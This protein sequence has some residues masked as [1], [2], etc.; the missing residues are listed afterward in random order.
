MTSCNQFFSLLPTLFWPVSWLFS[1]PKWLPSKDSCGQ[2]HRKLE[3]RTV[4]F[5]DVI[6]T[7]CLLLWSFTNC[8]TLMMA[9]LLLYSLTCTPYPCYDVIQLLVLLSLSFVSYTIFFQSI[10]FEWLAGLTL[11]LWTP[12]VDSACIYQLILKHR[13]RGSHLHITRWSVCNRD[14]ESWS[15][16]LVLDCL[17]LHFRSPWLV[18]CPCYES[19][20]NK[21]EWA[22]LNHVHV[23]AP[24]YLW[25][26]DVDW[27]LHTINLGHAI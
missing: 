20:M 5:A 13:S 16:K 7:L 11:T 12:L 18:D 8:A 21:R 6:R 9:F 10:L 19:S 14:Q 27:W 17:M 26:S 23:R 24:R 22:P 1:L 15:V 3:Q 2:Y 25:S 4:T